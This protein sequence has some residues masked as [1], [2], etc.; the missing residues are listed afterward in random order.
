[1]KYFYFFAL[2]FFINV[3]SQKIEKNIFNN[4]EFCTEDKKFC[5]ALQKD[6]F[7]NINYKDDQKNTITYNREYVSKYFPDLFKVE[8]FTVD[9][10]SGLLEEFKY[11]NNYSRTYE[12]D[13]FNKEIVE[14]NKNNKSV[15]YKDIYGKYQYEQTF[16]NQKI[17]ISEDFNGNFNYK[18]G[19]RIANL[20][21]DFNG[22]W[23]FEDNSGTQME[24]SSATWS[25]LNKRFGDK[26]NIFNYLIA[27]FL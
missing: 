11:E 14:D 7:N 3:S 21:K 9:F 12:I 20:E 23:K 2:F 15:L 8:N 25:L 27:N 13:I 16:D 5:A 1:M 17:N 24:F 4:Y 19:N 6:I 22:L 10:F 18:S 26:R